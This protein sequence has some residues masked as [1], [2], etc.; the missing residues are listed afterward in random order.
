MRRNFCRIWGERAGP[1]AKQFLLSSR[2]K[3]DPKIERRNKKLVCIAGEEGIEGERG[4][5]RR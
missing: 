2:P 1:N 4:R 3:T 5:G